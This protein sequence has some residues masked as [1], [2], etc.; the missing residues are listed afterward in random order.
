MDDILRAA[1]YITI[2]EAAELLYTTATQVRNLVRDGVIEGQKLSG[3]YLVKRDS[4]MAYAVRPGAKGRK[5]N[6]ERRAALA[7]P[8][9]TP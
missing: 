2:N 9:S 5:K 6:V 4:V 3:R 7:A 8:P 1:G